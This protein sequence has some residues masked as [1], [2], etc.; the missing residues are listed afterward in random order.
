MNQVKR[1]LNLALLLVGFILLVS[2]CGTAPSGEPIKVGL[3]APFSGS[4]SASS[5]AIQRGMLL[6]MDEMEVGTVGLDALTN[7]RGY[8]DLIADLVNEELSAESPPDAIV[9]IGGSSRYTLG[10]PRELIEREAN[11]STQFFYLQLSRFQL[12]R[13]RTTDS[14]EKLVK[15]QG[16]KVFRISS[17]QQ[18]GRAIRQMEQILSQNPG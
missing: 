7:P 18:F 15:R 17:P 5:E 3:I 14:I 11:M 8:L 4:L 10:F 1:L 6:A 2:A 16:G 12:R 9:F 13:Y